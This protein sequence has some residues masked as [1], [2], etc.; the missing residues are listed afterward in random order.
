MKI[1]F[2]VFFLVI[3][4]KLVIGQ[5]LKMDDLIKFHNANLSDA[6]DIAMN[7]G[8]KFMKREMKNEMN[9]VVYDQE[10]KKYILPNKYY[11]DPYAS[12]QS[13][14][15]HYLRLEKNIYRSVNFG[16]MFITSNVSNYKSIKQDI[17]NKGFKY[18]YTDEVE[19]H[20]YENENFKLL[21]R[22]EQKN[23]K[24]AYIIYLTAK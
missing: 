19:G 11:N 23:N 22:I 21:L 15:E 24:H 5:D 18:V 7:L 20:M 8:F 10:Y 17:D 4:G 1:I 9:I 13:P 14:I 2:L 6:E 16:V 3:S 12:L